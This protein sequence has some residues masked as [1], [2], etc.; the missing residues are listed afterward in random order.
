MM[1]MS[2]PVTLLLSLLVFATTVSY[3][4][5]VS[6]YTPDFSS[7]VT[8]GDSYTDNDWGRPRSMYG[9]DP[10]EALFDKASAP[11]D[12]LSSFAIA[13]TVTQDLPQMISSYRQAVSNGSVQPATVFGLE[14]GTNDMFDILHQIKDVVAGQDPIADAL[15]GEILVNIRLATKHLLRTHPGSSIILWNLET[16]RCWP[17]FPNI[18]NSQWDNIDTHYQRMNQAI[19]NAAQH[20]S[21]VLVLDMYRVFGQLCT[22]PTIIRGVELKRPPQ[23]SGWDYICA[24]RYHPTAVSNALIAN[25]MISDINLATGTS[26]PLYTE[27]EL[28]TLARIP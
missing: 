1:M 5:V 6:Q 24:D 21:R 25:Q 7:F 22:Q 16:A 9:A 15:V 18:T 4:P 13:G 8:I 10:F 19:E 12:V 20:S 2:K 26:I 3:K 27:G 28:A 23:W 14:I 11:S 17:A